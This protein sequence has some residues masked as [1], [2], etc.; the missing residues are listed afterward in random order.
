MDNDFTYKDGSGSVIYGVPIG[1]EWILSVTPS[2]G[3]C[4]DVIVDREGL[5][6]LYVWSG[7]QV[8]RSEAQ[9]DRDLLFTKVKL[10]FGDYDQEFG[11]T[12][13]QLRR[14]KAIVD[15]EGL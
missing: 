3:D 14:I 10:A 1:V 12:N 9:I 7:E 5:K 8:D 11:L 15:E 4:V 6:R 2:L 13:Y